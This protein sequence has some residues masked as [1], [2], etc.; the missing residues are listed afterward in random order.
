[1]SGLE[2]NPVELLSTIGARDP[3]IDAIAHLFQ[4]ELDSGGMGGALYTEAL[5][6]VLLIHLLR[7]Y[8]A[9]QPQRQDVVASLPLQRLQPVFDYIH[10]HLDQT[11][12]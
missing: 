12:H 10:S 4:T 11:L 6:Q 9:F 2:A 5:V 3:Q 1:M 7:Q 8:C